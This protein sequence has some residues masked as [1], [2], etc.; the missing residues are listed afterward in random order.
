MKFR[1]VIPSPPFPF[2]IS[3]DTRLMFLGS[4]FSEHI[5]DYLSERRFPVVANPFGI[6]FNPLSIASTLEVACGVRELD[7]RQ[8]LL[9]GDKWVSLAH[10]GRFS[11]PD[12]SLFEAG[13]HDSVSL[14][15]DAVQRADILFITLGTSY[16]YYHK[17]RQ[18]VVANCHKIPAQ[19][20]EKRRASVAQVVQAFETFFLWRQ[21]HRPDLK[22]V[23]TVSPVRHLADGF[24]ENQLS[25]S[26]LHLAVDEL[27]ALHSDTFYFPSY[28][29]LLDDLRDYRF[30]DHDLCHPS[31]QGVAYVLEQFTASFFSD[32]T[33]LR[34][35]EVEREVRRSSHIPL[36]K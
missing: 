9:F 14:A 27:C 17:E 5:S 13:I 24:H 34:M 29:I 6:L 31:A 25:K 30:Y 2:Q 28:E 35:Q 3:Y 19:N 4:C 22:V 18:T 26:I 36:Q 23:F 16:Y 10:H 11:H 21:N 8:F 12:R 33:L 15:R 1:T 32:D 7:E 20:F